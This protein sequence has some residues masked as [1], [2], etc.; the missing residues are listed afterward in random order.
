MTDYNTVDYRVV[1][2]KGCLIII[3]LFTVLERITTT[4]YTTLVYRVGGDKDD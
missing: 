3:F 4:D 2:D 1:E